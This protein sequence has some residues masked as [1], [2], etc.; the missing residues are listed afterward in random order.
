MRSEKCSVGA[1]LLVGLALTALLVL[2]QMLTAP[3]AQAPEPPDQGMEVIR[4]VNEE[5]A[6][7]KLPPLAYEP[8]LLA[9]AQ[10]RAE[11]SSQLFSHTRPNGDPWSTAFSDC[12]VF[13]HRGENLAYGQ[14]T[15]ARVVAAWMA[16]PG[17]KANILNEKYSMLAVG[18]YQKGNTLYWAQA[19]LGD[20]YGMASV[21][22]VPV[23]FNEPME[24]RI[25]GVYATVQKDIDLNLRAQG[26]SKAT[27]LTVMAGGTVVEVLES[28]KGWARVRT[29]NGMEGWCSEKYLDQ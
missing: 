17:H 19:F 23:E 14:K 12:G 16:S 22:D 29:S 27:V 9:V 3:A 8:A 7:Q 2:Y 6:K 1:K 13:G 15:P 10:L 5:R 24:I 11:E 26:N 4:L 18:V 25:D 20:P 28:S 21:P